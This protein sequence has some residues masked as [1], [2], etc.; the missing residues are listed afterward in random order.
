MVKM[1]DELR[2]SRSCYEKMI[3]EAEKTCPDIALG[4][5]LQLCTKIQVTEICLLKNKYADNGG[6]IHFSDE[7]M[8]VKISDMKSTCFYQ[9]PLD[10]VKYI[11]QVYDRHNIYLLEHCIDRRN[12][13]FINARGTALTPDG[14][15]RRLQTY[16]VSL[17]Y[18][19]DTEMID[20]V[21]GLEAIGKRVTYDTLRRCSV[22]GD[23]NGGNN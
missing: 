3:M 6:S 9:I 5:A 18:S 17:H 19:M 2:I 11:R 12:P 21:N 22:K 16:N 13:L 15:I 20:F 7:E 1:K 8:I 23:G 10:D 14:Y 4:I